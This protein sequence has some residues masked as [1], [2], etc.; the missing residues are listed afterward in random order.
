MNKVP[1]HKVGNFNRAKV[2]CYPKSKL[3][4]DKN[5]KTTYTNSLRERERERERGMGKLQVI[6]LE[7]ISPHPKILK[8]EYFGGCWQFCQGMAETAPSPSSNKV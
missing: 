7:L 5:N 6:L 1:H 4:C 8:K 3:G 2:P